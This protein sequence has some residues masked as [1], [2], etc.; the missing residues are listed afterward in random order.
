MSESRVS[1]PLDAL[2]INLPYNTE[3]EQAVIGAMLVDSS[4]QDDVF[5]ILRPEYFYSKQ[6]A[7]IF[8][9]MMILQTSGKPIDFVTVSESVVSAGIFSSPDDAKL[10]LYSVTE[11]VP[12]VSN[13]TAYARI[14]T[15]KY[16]QRTLINSCREVIELGSDGQTP[17]NELLDLAEQ[18]IYDIR[19]GRSTGDMK[20]IEDVSFQVLSDLEKLIGDDREKYLGISTGFSYL[21]RV[22]TGLN[23][24]DLIIL[25]A[26][27]SVGKTSFALNI[28]A[29]I[30]RSHPEIGIG[31]FSLEMTNEQLAQRII[32]SIAG[33]RSQ[34]FRTGEFNDDEMERITDAA[35]EISGTNIYLDDTSSISVQE[36]QAKARRIKNLGLIIVDYLQ[37]M[38]GSRRNE[39]RVNE[40]S[41]ITRNF[42]V[43]AKELNVPVMLLSQL[44]RG[45]EKDKRRPMLSDLRD[46]GSIEQDADIVMFLHRENQNTDEPDS[47]PP[48]NQD[49]LLMVSKNRHG[50]VTN[51]HLN[52]QSDITKFT[53][54]DYEHAE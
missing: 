47:A 48:A 38:S 8:R 45:T 53:P 52:F 23:R 6:N 50:E 4:V 13:V 27:P 35:A 22:T 26:R 41:E 51:M 25:A 16:L 3:A 7:D 12:S 54:F 15:D 43:L 5:G 36:L 37:L 9:E 19:S 17:A 49:I 34:K 2:G 30:A 46:S 42:K 29:N 32:S 18:K 14:V 40:I 24:S 10:Y 33:V 11:T 31:I 1:L 21:D 28:A 20:S 39:N 44:S